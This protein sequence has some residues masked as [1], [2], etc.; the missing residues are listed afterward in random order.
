MRRRSFLDALL[1]GALA[2]FL[3]GS[4]VAVAEESHQG[5]SPCSV[6]QGPYKPIVAN[7]DNLRGLVTGA[8]LGS[9]LY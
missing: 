8:L 5:K 2:G 3:A 6:R 9:L 1:P 4:P 7:P